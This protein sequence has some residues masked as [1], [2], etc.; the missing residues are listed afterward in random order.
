MT[1]HYWEKKQSI[2]HLFSIIDGFVRDEETDNEVKS[3]LAKYLCVVVSGFLETSIREIYSDY[4]RNKSHE[5][6]TNFVSSSLK[7]FQSA[8]M[9]NILT[10]TETFST[11]W[12]SELERKTIGEIKD[13]VD[14]LVDNRHHIAHGRDVGI[15]FDSARKYYKNVVKVLQLIEKQCSA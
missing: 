5:N 7:N 10:L 2:D 8:K 11:N 1:L 3:C 6:V 9:G 13:S 12:K 4:A 14:S 15:T